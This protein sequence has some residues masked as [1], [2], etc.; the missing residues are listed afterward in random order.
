MLKYVFQFCVSDFSAIVVVFIKDIPQTASLFQLIYECVYLARLPFWFFCF[1]RLQCF[2]FPCC[3]V[4]LFW[5]IVW[6]MIV[7]H[8]RISW[9]KYY[10]SDL[11]QPHKIVLRCYRLCIH[12]DHGYVFLIAHAL[13]Q[14]CWKSRANDFNSA[15]PFR[16]F[17][18]TKEM[19]N[20]CWSKF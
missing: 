19:L 1:V 7:L 3:S 14:Q 20:G 16:T 15:S 6:R 8:C 17:Q 10:H 5:K 13:A 4:D 18:R 2:P 9:L 12:G 11:L